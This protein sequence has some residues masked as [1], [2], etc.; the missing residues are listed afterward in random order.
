MGVASQMLST[1]SRKPMFGYRAMVY[2]ILGIGFLGF[3]VWGHHMFMSGMNP[4]SAIAFAMLDHVHRRAL[5]DQDVQLDR[6]AVGRQDPLR[7]PRCYWPGLRL[8]CS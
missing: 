7:L 1:F 2:A 3:L 6:H 8:A 4:Y 5:G